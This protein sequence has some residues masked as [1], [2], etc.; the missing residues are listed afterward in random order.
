MLDN[1]LQGALIALR[2]FGLG[3]TTNIR[4][5]ALCRAA[6]QRETDREQRRRGSFPH[7]KMKTLIVAAAAVI[8]VGAA[9]ATAESLLGGA[10]QRLARVLETSP[11]PGLASRPEA[12]SIPA[13]MARTYRVLGRPQQ[14]ADQP[15]TAV[16]DAASVAFWGENASLARRA[17]TTT[18]GETAY[19]VPGN[20]AIC[21]ETIPDVIHGCG[22]YPRRTP[23]EMIGGTAVCSPGLPSNE[24]EVAELLPSDATNITL[25]L[26]NGSILPIKPVNDVFILD[27]QR[28]QPLPTGI[29]WSDASGHEQA[30]TGTPTNAASNDCGSP[31]GP[32]AF[33][34]PAADPVPVTRLPSR[35]R[36]VSNENAA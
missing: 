11:P 21:L 22:P 13:D 8:A 31:H 10:N 27:L 9:T 1:E 34:A 15:P 16:L 28:T 12:T 24:I 30:N 36:F 32:E 18:T 35:R 14:T 33:T 23:N 5:D 2:D 7:N 4:A 19:V 29:S 26:T 6:L 17:L 25:H 20:G 3:D